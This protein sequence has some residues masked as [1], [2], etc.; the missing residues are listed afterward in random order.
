[1][2]KSSPRYDPF[3]EEEEVNSPV[4]NVTSQ[5]NRYSNRTNAKPSRYS[6]FERLLKNSS[7]F[8]SKEQASHIHSQEP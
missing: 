8:S 4:S 7:T 3:F 1:M 6:E 5:R 2:K